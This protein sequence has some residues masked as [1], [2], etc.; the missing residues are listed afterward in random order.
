MEHK[1]IDL[2]LNF[3]LNSFRKMV[4]IIEVDEHWQFD[5]IH[6][7]WM[8][9]CRQISTN[10]RSSIELSMVILVLKWKTLRAI[11]EGQSSS[12]SSSRR[13]KT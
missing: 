6:W 10:I 1:T 12:S 3:L 9:R 8:G 11:D 13:K 4:D 2:N 7:N 5:E